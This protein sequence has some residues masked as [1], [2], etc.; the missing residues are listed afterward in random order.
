ML[1]ARLMGANVLIVAATLALV[2]AVMLA[3]GLRGRRVGDH[4]MCRRCGFDLFGRP[5]DSHGCPECGADVTRDRSI[6]LGVRQRRRWAVWSGSVMLLP[7]I[8]TLA[9][10]GWGALYGVFPLY[11]LLS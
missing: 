4:P 6:V 3:L 8:S 9:I 5:A 7:A 10:L 1:C 2:G 11:V